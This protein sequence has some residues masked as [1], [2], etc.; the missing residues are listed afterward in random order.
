ML[1]RHE[2]ISVCV[3]GDFNVNLGGPHYYGRVDDKHAV[4]KLLA[5]HDLMALTAFEMTGP[6]QQA[7]F[8]LIDHIAVSPA[9]FRLAQPAQVWQRENKEG[10]KMSDHCGVA[11]E[12]LSDNK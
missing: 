9:L 12:F 2:G 8:G 11:V 6:V 10:E 5:D 4:R 3:A 1:R 7:G